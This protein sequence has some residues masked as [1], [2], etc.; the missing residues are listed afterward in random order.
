MASRRGRTLV[1]I[2]VALLVVGAL[3]ATAAL[4][5]PASTAPPKIVGDVSFFKTIRCDPG[6]WSGSPTSFT[7]EWLVGG[8]PHATGAKFT[9][10]QAFYMGGYDLSCRV[11]A[12][13]GGG[14]TA[15]AT[16]APV[17]PALGKTKLTITKVITKSGGQIT[18]KGKLTPLVVGKQFGGGTVL[19]HR[20]APASQFGPKAVFQLGDGA[21]VSKKGT[22][23]VRGK[24][25]AG[26]RTIRVDFYPG[27][28]GF[29]LW[30]PASVSR[31]VTVLE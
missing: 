12:T 20:K 18:F 6:A 11:T 25:K 27:N 28:S 14:A 10:D 8:S 15:T 22:F 5:V 23:T 9:I 19:L 3:S 31:T 21:S 24:D 26:K 1:S 17:R 7:Y 30:A 13:D 29:G 16:S 4:A 2:A